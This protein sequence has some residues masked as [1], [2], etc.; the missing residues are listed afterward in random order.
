[1]FLVGV[2]VAAWGVNGIV[3][4]SLYSKSADTPLS[5]I[6]EALSPYP[7]LAYY[8][9]IVVGVSISL[10]AFFWWYKSFRKIK[11]G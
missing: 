4:K 10:M 9:F 2:Y 6:P 8:V 11:K 7:P 3:L 5:G 1:M